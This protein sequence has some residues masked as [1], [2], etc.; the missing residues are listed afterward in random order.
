MALIISAKEPCI[1]SKETCIS[2]KEAYQKKK[3]HK[4]EER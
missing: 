4:E 1:T 2:A 3:S